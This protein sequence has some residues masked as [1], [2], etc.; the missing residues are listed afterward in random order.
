LRLQGGEKA[1]SSILF[2]HAAEVPNEHT[3]AKSNHSMTMAPAEQPYFI[4][5]IDGGGSK[6]AYTVGV[7]HELERYWGV[8]LWT[9]FDMI[10]GTSSGAIIGSLLGLGGSVTNIEK[11]YLNLIPSIMRHKLSRRRSQALRQHARHIFGE[12][13][14]EAFKTQV[15]I[16]TT[17]FDAERPMIFKSSPD[18]AHRLKASFEPGFG[19]TIADAVIASCAAFPFFE[20]VALSTSNQGNPTLIDGGFSANNPTLLAIADVHNA[21]R[22]ALSRLRVLSIGVGHYKEPHK[23]W[24]HELLFKAWPFQMIQ[25]L[26]TTNT[27]TIEH[28]RK[29]LFPD[30]TCVRIDEAFP[31]AQYATDLLEADPRQLRKLIVLGRDSFRIHETQIHAHFPATQD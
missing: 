4:L 14:F 19:C 3:L 22:I 20:K 12:Q 21:L 28:L 6:G 26:L 1:A 2:S 31:D 17:D 25:K 7:L 11:L 8:P 27:N 30:T 18:Q 16:I 13:R 29:I 23:S 9:R 5:S 15:S 24:Y 10:V